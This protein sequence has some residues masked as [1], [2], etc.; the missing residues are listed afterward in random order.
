MKKV[1]ITTL[2]CSK[3]L[4]DSEVLSGQLEAHE[5][6][7]VDEP[8]DSDLIIVN[9]CG[10]IQS[11]KEESLQAIFEAIKLKEDDPAKKVFVTGCL[12]ERYK[13]DI[14]KKIPEVDAIF[15]T[16]AY[17]EILGALGK[18]HAANDNLHRMRKVTTP[19]HFAYLKISEGCNHTC[20]FCAIPGIRGK[21]RSRSIESLV[22]EAA[23]LAANGA[24][25]LILISQ[26]TSSYGK[27]I[28]N[29]QNIVNLLKALAQID[30]IE[31]I[32]V[33]YWYPTNFP[34]EV[35][36]LM[37]DN[38]KILPYIDMPIQHVSDYMLQLMRRGE[39]KET[40]YKIFNRIRAEIPDIALRTTLI[41]GHPGETND[42]FS[43]LLAFI[44]DF[45]F[46]RMGSFLYSD[47]ENTAAYL[48]QN[49]VEVDVA[50]QRQDELMSV[51][52]D[53]SS[54]KNALL[55]GSVQRV[56]LDEY[57]INTSTYSGRT[58]R[59]APEIDNEIIITVDK[60]YTFKPGD[61][62]DVEI[63]DSGEYELFGRFVG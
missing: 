49:K 13:P 10:F 39:R 59:D 32:R 11:A 62:A 6:E 63:I 61:F 46:D 23:K 37:K 12:S 38:P 5:F 21:L 30:G 1:H 60:E 58:Y 45:Q 17:K 14:E 33:L 41:V 8:V 50:R 22:D 31:W 9:T 2:G 55:V 43:E 19:R 25:E 57:D 53:L 27:D 29:K 52:R 18:K 51:Q 24:K 36:Q 35:I 34:F 16:E 40:I 56:L 7:M 44:K 20:A 54:K 15:G 28:Y 26:D 42:D 3:N 4:V 47:E 48:L